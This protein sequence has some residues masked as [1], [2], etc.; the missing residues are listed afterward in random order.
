MDYFI[1]KNREWNSNDIKIGSIS[2]DT[3]TG[4]SQ[5][6]IVTAI[7]LRGN[8]P[9][10]EYYILALPVVDGKPVLEES[11]IQVTEQITVIE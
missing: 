9:L 4:F 5:S 11:Q 1:S 3:M 7:Q 2:F 8:I 10:G 6:I